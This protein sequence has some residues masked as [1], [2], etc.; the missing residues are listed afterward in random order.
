MLGGPI[1]A[2]AGAAIGHLYDDDD[3]TPQNEKKARVL[4]LAYFFSCAA[5]IAKADGGVSDRQS[6]RTSLYTDHAVIDFSSQTDLVTIRRAYGRRRSRGMTPWRAAAEE[7]EAA[8]AA[9]TSCSLLLLW[10]GL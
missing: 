6:P 3:P 4:Y 8:A 7:E 1:G 2:L 10:A 9:Q 5:K